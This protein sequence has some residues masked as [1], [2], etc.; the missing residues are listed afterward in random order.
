MVFV[1]GHGR[2]SKSY[3]HALF[4]GHPQVLQIHCMLKFHRWWQL[5]GC[6]KM[7]IQELKNFF[8]R[9]SNL[10]HV[11]FNHYDRPQLGE[12]VYFGPVMVDREKYWQVFE[13]CL[14]DYGL[15]RR[16]AFLAFH[17]A[18]IETCPEVAQTPLWLME[19]AHNHSSVAAILED[20]PQAHF[21]HMMRDPRTSY[22]SYLRSYKHTEARNWTTESWSQ[23]YSSFKQ[24]QHWKKL[25]GPSRYL[26]FKAEL[27]NYDHKQA[28]EKISSWLGLSWHEHL[29]QA[30][31]GGKEWKTNQREKGEQVASS[32]RVEATTLKRSQLRKRE[33]LGISFALAREIEE[34][35]YEKIEVS[36]FDGIFYYFLFLLIPPR[37]EFILRSQQTLGRRLKESCLKLLW[38][39]LR[40]PWAFQHFKLRGIPGAR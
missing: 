7:E 8:E 12:K 17:Q 27:L 2:T 29:L 26:I 22:S 31:V 6:E 3:L 19:N 18:Y 34:N 20:F 35:Y 36:K 9:K 25:L 1:V 16:N 37:E 28:M 13:R 21:I 14:K 5:F 30:S 39:P 23:I 32:Y 40:L 24:A 11:L 10:R 4:D 33:L 38:A 15:S